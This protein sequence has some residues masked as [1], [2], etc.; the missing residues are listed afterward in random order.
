[1]LSRGKGYLFSNKMKSRN[2][3]RCILLGLFLFSCV[4]GLSAQDEAF[5]AGKKKVEKRLSAFN[6][7]EMILDHVVDKHSWHLCDWKGKAVVVHL[8][9]ILLWKGEIYVFSSKEFE[10]PQHTYGDFQLRTSAPYKGKIVVWET[11]SDGSRVIASRL[12]FDF[13]ITKTVFGIMV[14]AFLL[15]V[16]FFFV[17]R[18]YRKN[19]EKAPK[20]LAALFEPVYLFIRDEIV[21]PNMGKKYGDR[22]L[23]YLATLFFFILFGN[24]LGLVPFFPFGANMTGN[25]SVTLVLA[26][27]TFVITLG[28]STR[29]YWKHVFNTPGV[30]VWMKLPIP[31]MPLI[32]LL[33]VVIKPFVLMVR[34]FANITA[35]HI[36]LLGFVSLVLIFGSN[37][38]VLGYAVSP[39]TVVLGLFS[40][41]L[42][43]L[44]SFIQA[45][46]FTLL[47]ANY[48]GGALAY[49]PTE[50]KVKSA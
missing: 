46:I 48:F 21:Y 2:L 5:P 22:Y 24:V 6:A 14:S 19:G 13:S 12:P 1:M 33:E 34:L 37:N 35:G 27:L 15:L 8:P 16:L 17:V 45:Y 50:R 43:L 30:P 23:P 10:N 3:V 36:V 40:D 18:S 4:S 29:T 44:V 28:S 11:A 20:G 39:L 32:E 47:S 49:E 38:A 26:L 41:C 42:E 7:G 31:L 25:I 9:V